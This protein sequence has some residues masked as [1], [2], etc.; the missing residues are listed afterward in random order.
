MRFV[1]PEEWGAKVL[2]DKVVWSD[3]KR[4][5]PHLTIVHYGGGTN[6][7]GGSEWGTPPYSFEAECRVL[8][9]WEAYHTGPSKGMRA[10]AYNFGIGQTGRVYWLRGPQHSNGGQWSSDD[11]PSDDGEP[12][13]YHSRAVVFILGG[14]QRPSRAAR[15]AFGRLW[16]ESPLDSTVYCHSDLSDTS[17]PGAHLTPWV[18]GRLFIDDLGVWQRGE[19]GRTVLSI[20]RR[21]QDLGFKPAFG[22]GDDKVFT[23]RL[24]KRVKE[25]Q[26]VYRGLEPDG[27]VGYDTFE[28]MSLAKGRG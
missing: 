14:A 19:R 26:T 10:I 23:R 18:D 2:T 27:I 6:A 17:C 4:Y 16:V 12:A 21:L 15:T 20:R 1:M 3:D 28:A 5:A 25:F 24:E 9:S 11:C 8:R 22:L 13:N 7:A